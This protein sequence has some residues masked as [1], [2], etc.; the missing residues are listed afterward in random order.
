MAG[1]LKPIDK[2]P[3]APGSPEAVRI[4]CKCP[5]DE[6]HAGAGAYTDIYGYP[7]FWF[8]RDCSIHGAADPIAADTK[9][10]EIMP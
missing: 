7:I 5:V 2:K 1:K 10:K 6:N 9:L 3:Y 8:D 4:G